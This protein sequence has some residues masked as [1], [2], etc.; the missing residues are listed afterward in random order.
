MSTMS[1]DLYDMYIFPKMYFV[2]NCIILM[3]KSNMS[4]KSISNNIPSISFINTN[5]IVY[6]C[7]QVTCHFDIRIN[8]LVISKH[9]NAFKRL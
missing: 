9:S 8:A 2:I 5:C 6:I 1:R 3:L 7:I 4:V